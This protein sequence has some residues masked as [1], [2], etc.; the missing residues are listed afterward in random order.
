MQTYFFYSFL[1]EYLLNR[2]HRISVNPFRN[3]AYSRMIGLNDPKSTLPVPPSV[4]TPDEVSAN[5]G[6]PLTPIVEINDDPYP[7]ANA[8][9]NVCF[10]SLFIFELHLT[11]KF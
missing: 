9:S 7:A 8:T 3:W 1:D 11:N 5:L 6:N 2:L 4:A 10:S